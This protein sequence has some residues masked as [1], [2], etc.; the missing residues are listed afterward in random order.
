MKD[1][2]EFPPLFISSAK[3]SYLT[4]RDGRKVIDGIASWWCKSLGHGDPAIKSAISDQL[5]SFEHVM[6]GN[7]TYEKIILLSEKLSTL[8]KGLTRVMYAG[9]GSSA[10]EIALKMSL[11]SRKIRGEIQRNSFLCLENAYHG[12]TAL[13]MSVSDLGIYREPYESILTKTF[14][15]R[16]IPYVSGKEDPV[17]ENCGSYWPDLEAQLNEH[18]EKLTAVIVEPILQ[19]A[20]GMKIYSKDFLKRLRTWTK[21]R[22]IHLIAD[23]IM[24]GFGR[25]GLPLACDHARVEPDFLCLGKA[26]TAGFLPLSAVLTSEEIYDLFYDDYESGKSFLHSHTH[27]GNALAVSASLAMFEVMEQEKIYENLPKLERRLQSSFARVSEETEEFK[28]IR[29]IGGVVAG[30]LVN[31]RGEFRPGFEFYKRAL[32]K[33]ALL[34]PI[35]STVYWLTPLNIESE[36][37]AELAR[38]TSD[39]C[40]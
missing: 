15:L 11:H 7:T 34:R 12:E 21:E 38:I 19:G 37:I 14:V 35:G 16:R 29:G 30:D 20:A 1:L 24:T 3:G 4:L 23:E 22:G 33:G 17:W 5:E 13:T 10:V 2:V 8:S 31:R 6:F 9:D 39:A 27:T 32:K 28:N 26:L 18:Q 40:R 36:V 25:T